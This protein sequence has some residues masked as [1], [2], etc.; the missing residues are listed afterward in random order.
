MGT[1]V[2]GEVVSF[3]GQTERNPWHTIL[4]RLVFLPGYVVAISIAYVMLVGAWGTDEANR[5]WHNVR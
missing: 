1:S 2:G 5:F 4:R 3:I